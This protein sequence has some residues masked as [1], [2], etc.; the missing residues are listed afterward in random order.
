MS[1]GRG[2]A[3]GASSRGIADDARVINV[4]PPGSR[5]SRNVRSGRSPPGI[6]R[7][8]WV[9]QAEV[10]AIAIG[11][12]ATVDEP[13]VKE[14]IIR[15]GITSV[16]GIVELL[17]GSPASHVGDGDFLVGRFLG[18]YKVWNRESSN[19]A[20]DGHHDQ[21]FDE[22]KTRTLGRQDGRPFAG[23]PRGNQ[24]F[25]FFTD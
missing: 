20:D 19:D 9:V 23:C 2:T 14:L 17:G 22:G 18:L 11:C 13:V 6:A 5:L 8:R 12:A 3:V 1:Q 10:V 15:V 7:V 21:Q 4:K 25:H 16:P 24:S